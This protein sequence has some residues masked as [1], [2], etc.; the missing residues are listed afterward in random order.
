VVVNS[1]GCGSECQAGLDYARRTLASLGRLQSRTQTEL[2][3]DPSLLPVFPEAHRAQMIFVVD[4]LGNLMM[5]YD[6]SRD[7]KGLREDLQH[8]LELSQIG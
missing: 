6:S 5:R 7:P 3:S 4:P 8:L 2:V 1:D